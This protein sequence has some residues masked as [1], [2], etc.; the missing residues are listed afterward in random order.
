MHDMNHILTCDQLLLLLSL[1]R[2]LT[3]KLLRLP[4]YEEDLT[5]LK[6]RGYIT[7]DLDLT[8]LGEHRVKAAL[9]Q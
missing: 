7:A 2:G 1:H 8:E 5:V 6:R 4:T 3:G 9:E